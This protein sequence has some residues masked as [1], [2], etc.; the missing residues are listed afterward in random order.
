MRR[1]Q[2]SDRAGPHSNDLSPSV[3][4]PN[5]TADVECVP[6]DFLRSFADWIS[7]TGT[8]FCER[9]DAENV[10]FVGRRRLFAQVT[11]RGRS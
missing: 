1:C 6:P 8:G 3:D 4:R 2:L 5:G 11:V 7:G 9:G 10:E